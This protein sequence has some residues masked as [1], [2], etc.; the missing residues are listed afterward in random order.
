MRI[1]AD[2]DDRRLRTGCRSDEVQG[3]GAPNPRPGGVQMVAGSVFTS[4]IIS[5]VTR[6]PLPP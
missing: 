2:D 4:T 3:E 5:K 1:M 6:A